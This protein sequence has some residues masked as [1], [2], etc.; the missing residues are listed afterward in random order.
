MSLF[1]PGIEI[2][3]ASLHIWGKH[4]KYFGKVK[5]LLHSPSICGIGSLVE[6][7]LITRRRD[8]NKGHGN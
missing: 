5:E 8:P 4:A 7:L 2:Y 3:S 6:H 1:S